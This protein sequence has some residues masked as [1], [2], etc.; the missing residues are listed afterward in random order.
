MTAVGGWKL[1]ARCIA[2]SFL[3]LV[4]ISLFLGHAK[5]TRWPGFLRRL[6]MIAG[7]ALAISV[8]TYI[9]VPSG[10]IFFG[11]LHQIALASV[12][13]LAFLRLP[14]VV[15]MVAAAAVIAAPHYLRSE[16][17]NDP[18]WWW[19]GL[20]ESRPRS[21]DYVPVF[22]WF[23]AVLAGITAAK[24]AEQ[25]GLF[26]KLATLRAPR[27]AWPLVFGGRHS[28]AVYLIHQ[29]VLIASVWL[30]AQVFP[31][32][33]ETREVRFLQSCEAACNE[34]RDTE[35]CTR[36]CVCMLGTL[37]R[38]G[39]IEGV[40]AGDRSEALQSRVEDIAGRCTIETDN[41]MLEGGG[42]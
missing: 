11:I 32:S 40:Y 35:F 3:F 10:F 1:F 12:L 14:A 15:T 38:G 36:Y 24:I 23:G 26:A 30:F 9:A 16:F 33:Q 25:T 31:P 4:G 18:W 21:N 8:V 34:Q 29:P 28:L 19:A 20:S 27:W 41:A 13:G 22:P 39:A 7:A 6:A 17:F 2:S 37:E 42:Q 5:G